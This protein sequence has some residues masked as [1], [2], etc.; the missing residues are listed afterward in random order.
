MSPSTDAHLTGPA[1]DAGLSDERTPSS[2]DPFPYLVKPKNALPKTEISRPSLWIADLELLHHWVTCTSLTLP[3]SREGAGSLWGTDV[4]K[5]ALKNHFLMHALL[6]VS[7]FHLAF[8]RPTQ[9]GYYHIQASQHQNLAIEGTRAALTGLTAEASHSLFATSSLLLFSGFSGLAAQS[10]HFHPTVNDIVDIFLL[11]RGMHGLL[12]TFHGVLAHGPLQN[13]FPG[14]ECPKPTPPTSLQVLSS[15]LLAVE[16]QIEDGDLD[17]VMMVTKKGMRSLMLCIQR[18]VASSEAPAVR[19]VTTWPISLDADF[20][21]ALRS[22]QPAATCVLAYFC[23]ILRVIEPSSWY[24]RGWGS[25]LARSIAATIDHSWEDVI[26]WPL[27]F[28]AA[29]DAAAQ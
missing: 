27:G 11:T 7:A 14:S 8:L 19:V 26:E 2:S 13:L 15:K 5:L 3:P 9:R 16:Q 12:D 10:D 21:T 6:A 17:Q 23:V 18:A 25:G 24:I 22:S 28:I 20:I 1:V 29:L 4:P